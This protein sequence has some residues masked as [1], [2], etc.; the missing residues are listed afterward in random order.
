MEAIVEWLE[1]HGGQIQLADPSCNL[2]FL[3][4]TLSW[5][6]RFLPNNGRLLPF[7]RRYGVIAQN[8]DIVL[9]MAL[10]P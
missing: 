10:P 6:T 5:S 2:P 9:G 1:T 7:L 4:D 8:P 3:S